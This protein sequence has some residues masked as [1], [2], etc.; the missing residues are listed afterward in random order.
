M[1]C[2]KTSCLHKA[3][4]AKWTELIRTQTILQTAA[5]KAPF[6]SDKDP[7]QGKVYGLQLFRF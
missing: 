7:I 6:V 2:E 4:V 1:M 5:W 3:A